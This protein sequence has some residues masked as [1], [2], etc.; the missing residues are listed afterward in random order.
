MKLRTHKLIERTMS[1]VFLGALLA[2]LSFGLTVLYDVPFWQ[3]FGLV[4]GLF[5]GITCVLIVI[6]W[7]VSKF[8]VTPTDP[9]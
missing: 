9:E 5:V 7:A 1:L 8:R 6:F 3:I 2:G 4:I